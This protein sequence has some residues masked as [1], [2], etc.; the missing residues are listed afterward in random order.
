MRE[1]LLKIYGRTLAAEMFGN[2]KLFDE[3]TIMNDEELKL[4]NL[5]SYFD[6]H[7]QSLFFI[8]FILPFHY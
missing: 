3:T 5:Y 6:V 1:K 4:M 8:R 2:R 7:K